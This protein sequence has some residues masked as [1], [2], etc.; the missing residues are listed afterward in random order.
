MFSKL[1]DKREC[2]EVGGTLLTGW[3]KVLPKS[4]NGM[5]E[6]MRWPNFDIILPNVTRNWHKK[7]FS[8]KGRVWE[9]TL[10]LRIGISWSMGIA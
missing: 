7:T 1:S 8:G 6:K 9:L 3:K 5:E 2:E 4:S 10:C